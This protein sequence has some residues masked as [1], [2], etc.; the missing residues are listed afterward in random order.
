MET[1]RQTDPTLSGGRGP[2]FPWLVRIP[3]DEWRPTLQASKEL[4]D[5]RNPVASEE[6]AEPGEMGVH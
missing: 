1:H 2:L 4:R 6:L 5:K 3:E